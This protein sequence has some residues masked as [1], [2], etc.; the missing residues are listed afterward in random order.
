ML[1]RVLLI[2][3]AGLLVAAPAL[4]EVPEDLQDALQEDG[5]GII[6]NYNGMEEGDEIG[7]YWLADAVSLAEHRCKLSSF[8]STTGKASSAAIAV[9][10]KQLPRALRQACSQGAKSTL[11]VEA[12]L[13][14]AE[15]AN[16]GKAWIPFAGGHLMQAGVGLE[17]VFKNRAGKVVAKL[18]HSARQGG[19]Q[20][21]AAREVVEDVAEFVEDN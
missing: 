14:W 5:R 21:A 16:V 1:S 2:F 6:K 10:K 4:A 9:F 3:F 11:K 18:R 15:E 8:K 20:A 17:L 12:A 19:A 7:W 13:F